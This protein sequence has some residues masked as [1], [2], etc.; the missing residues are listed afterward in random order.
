MNLAFLLFTDRCIEL[1]EGGLVFLVFL[2]VC[3][4]F[5]LVLSFGFLSKLDGSEVKE[6]ETVSVL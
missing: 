3:V 4:R 5:S 6:Q 2:L 1:F